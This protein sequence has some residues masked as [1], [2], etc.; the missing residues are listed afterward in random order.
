VG[1]FFSHEARRS[2]AVRPADGSLAPSAAA[3]PFAG[4]TWMATLKHFQRAPTR[5]PITTRS[6]CTSGYIAHAHGG[7]IS[8]TSTGVEGT[9][10]A[11]TLPRTVP[12]PDG[13][14]RA[15]RQKVQPLIPEGSIVSHH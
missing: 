4:D 8:V 14:Q 3:C 5:M 11:V 15:V 10:I 6:A 2:R 9:T 12:A 13:G 1:T 7:A